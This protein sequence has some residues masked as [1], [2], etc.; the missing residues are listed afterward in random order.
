[1]LIAEGHKIVLIVRRKSSLEGLESQIDVK[2]VDLFYADLSIEE[3]VIN[4][5]GEICQRWDRVDVLF[6]NAGVLL[7]NVYLS[8][9]GN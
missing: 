6:N 3:E 5:A 2:E 1:M 9:Q 7:D 8:K 4:V